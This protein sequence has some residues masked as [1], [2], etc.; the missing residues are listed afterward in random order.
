MDRTKIL[1]EHRA[2]LDALVSG[3]LQT[4]INAYQ[5]HIENIK[6]LLGVK[7]SAD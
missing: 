2:L 6:K 4:A 5:G 7:D 1:E 3:N